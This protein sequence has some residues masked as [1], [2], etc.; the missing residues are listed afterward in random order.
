MFRWAI[1]VDMEQK[2]RWNVKKKYIYLCHL[3]SLS[4]GPNHESVHG[5]LNTVC[6]SFSGSGR[7]GG[8]LPGTARAAAGVAWRLRR[9]RGMGLSRGLYMLGSAES[10]VDLMSAVPHVSTM[11]SRRVWSSMGSWVC[12]PMPASLIHLL[13]HVWIIKT[14]PTTVLLQTISECVNTCQH[15]KHLQKEVHW[16]R[17]L[18]QPVCCQKV[19]LGEVTSPH[20]GVI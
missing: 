12:A 16:M 13:Q 15:W 2:K 17:L 19:D 8:G 6:G 4:S 5:S 11:G 10:G 9:W 7:G 14:W 20:T 3:A 1:L 18:D